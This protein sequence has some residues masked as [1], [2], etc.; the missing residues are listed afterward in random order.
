MDQT[1]YRYADGP[2]TEASLVI[3]ASPSVLWTLVS[4]INLPARCST[5]FRGAEWVD[6]ATGPALGARFEGRNHHDAIGSWTTPATVVEYEVDRTF[7]WSIG[8]P[9]APSA[10]WRFRLAPVGDSTLVTQ[11]MRMGPARSGLSAAIDAMPDKESKIIRRRLEEHR[12]NMEANL[13]GIKA[14]VR[15]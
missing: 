5:E 14:L 10:S 3:D 7:G 15:P 4:D 11:W 9:A 2:T 12:T 1:E 8:D 6:G 13:A